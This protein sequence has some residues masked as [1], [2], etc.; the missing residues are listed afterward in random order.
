M[1]RRKV[2]IFCLLLSHL[3]LN[4]ARGDIFE[5]G[6]LYFED[7]PDKD[8]ISK[9]I[10]TAVVQ[11]RSGF[12][13]IGTLSGLVRFDG[14]RFVRFVHDDDDPQSISGDHIRALWL[15]EDGRIWIGTN[16]DGLSVYDAQTEQF[17]HYLYRQGQSEGVSGSKITALSGDGAGGIWIGTN[18]GLDYLD[19]GTGEFTRYHSEAQTGFKLDDNRINSLLSDINGDLWVGTHSGLNRIKQGIAEKHPLPFGG[20][21]VYSIFQTTDGKIWLGASNG[22]AWW[23]SPENDYGKAQRVLGRAGEKVDSQIMSIAQPNSTEVWLGTFDVG[24]YVVSAEDGRLIKN[25]RHDVTIPGSLNFDQIGALYKDRSGLLW[26]GTWGGGMNRFNP[27]VKAFRTLRHSP[28]QRQMLSHMSVLSVLAVSNGNVWVGTQSGGI[29]VISPN[30]GVIKRFKANPEDVNALYD[31]GVKALAETNNG[32]I[33]VGT[34]G[35]GLHRYNRQTQN[36]ERLQLKLGLGTRNIRSLLP[37]GKTGIW[38]GTN[39]GLFHYDWQQQQLTQVFEHSKPG[40][41]IALRFDYLAM[42][43]SGELWAGTDSGLFVKSA[44]NQ[45]LLRFKNQADTAGSLS[46]TSINSLWVDEDDRLWVSTA[47]GLDRLVSFDGRNARFE[48]INE[49]IGK[50]KGRWGNVISDK[51]GRIWSDDSV[52]DPKDWSYRYFT[53]TDGVDISGAWLGSVDKLADGTLMFGGFGL[54]LIK[55]DLLQDWHYQPPVVFSEL[56]VDGRLMPV[57]ALKQ[58]KLPAESKSFTLEFASLDYASPMD[59][60]YAYQLKGYDERWISVDAT[61]RRLTYTNLDP[62]SYLLR[63]RGSNQRGQWSPNELTLQVIQQA[64]WYQSWWFGALLGILAISVIFAVFKLRLYQLNRN[65]QAL[66]ELVEERTE[67]LFEA[68]QKVMMISQLGREITTSLKFDKV[69]DKLYEHLHSMLPADIFGVGIYNK[70]KQLIEVKF[71]VQ[72]GVHFEPYDRDFNDKDQ[73]PV[74][75]IEHRKEVLINDL[76]SEYHHYI[77]R[78]DCELRTRLLEDGQYSRPAQSM[79]VSPLIL[80]ERVLGYVTLQSFNKNAYNEQNLSMVRM[81]AAYAAIA[82]DNAGTHEHLQA[83]QQQLVLQEKMASLGTLTAGI[84]HEINNPTNFVHLGAQNLAVDLDKFQEFLLSL[85]DDEADK[86]VEAALKQQFAPLFEHLATIKNGTE[87]IKAIV[88]NLRTFTRLDSADKQSVDIK[89]CIDSTIDL[90][91]TKYQ[92]LCEFKVAFEQS[93][94]LTCFV[95]QLNQVFMNIIVNACDAIAE[96]QKCQPD[97]DPGLVRIVGSKI[98]NGIEISVS[99][100]GCGMDEK[101]RLRVFEPFFTTKDVGSGTGLGMAI[102]FGIIKEHG[103]N[104]TVH[105]IPGEG[106]CIRLWLPQ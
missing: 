57:A 2:L 101:T 10:V 43:S 56:S 48:S 4:G 41:A 83:T 40:A 44:D 37:D 34:L 61:K 55:P 54:L 14:Y 19:S 62:G 95:A 72:Q 102:S 53:R 17:S 90:V 11:D 73:L 66:N 16:H 35:Y 59:N 20:S 58:L 33:W 31:N 22:G 74:W 87:R 86:E 105:S 32:D 100:N 30:S 93:T 70:D 12:I 49:K 69:L 96:R 68:N 47:Q 97:C 103:G 50:P 6:L 92:N 15:A 45:H 23:L 39:R 94:T 1:H 3:L 64:A 18:N 81:L 26:I 84:A 89:E 77:T 51:Q 13:W 28:V 78:L 7:V 29:D 91:R 80:Q 99:D 8:N 25:I 24:I 9:G 5:Q 76:H 79:I 88:Q 42:Q 85:T 71:A 36:F 21:E 63:I 52:I 104:I 38:I 75:C 106:T 27:S 60:R 82:L 65:Q 67:A 98:D 46:H